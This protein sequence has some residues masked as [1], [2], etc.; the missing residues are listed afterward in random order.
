MQNKCT[1][2]SLG[3]MMIDVYSQCLRN[4]SEAAATVVTLGLCLVGV[5]INLV[6]SMAQCS[7]QAARWLDQDTVLCLPA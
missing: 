2:I 6:K 4:E 3:P 7:P 1:K 5:M